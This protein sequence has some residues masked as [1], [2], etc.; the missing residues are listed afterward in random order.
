MKNIIIAT[1][2][3]VLAF[4]IAIIGLIIKSE[5]IILRTSI[6]ILMIIAFFFGFAD[7][8]E[9]KEKLKWKKRN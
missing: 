5:N 4:T 7:D 1:I 8:K 3:G 2:S 6:I 9:T